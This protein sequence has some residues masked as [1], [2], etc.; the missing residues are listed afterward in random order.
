MVKGYC[1]KCRVKKDMDKIIETELKNGR[2]AFYGF[3][4]DCKTKMFRIGDLAAAKKK[5][6]TA[7]G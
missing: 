2:P 4:P 6:L 5:E 1:V 7:G 3:C